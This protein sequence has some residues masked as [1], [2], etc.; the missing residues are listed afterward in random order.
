M[1]QAKKVTAIVT[2]RVKELAILYLTKDGSLEHYE[3]CIEELE[4]EVLDF[5]IQVVLA[6]HELDIKHQ[7]TNKR[8]TYQTYGAWA[9][10]IGQDSCQDRTPDE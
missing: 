9:R 7:V 4:S 3:D 6:T 8:V 2:R 5:K 1:K 10:D